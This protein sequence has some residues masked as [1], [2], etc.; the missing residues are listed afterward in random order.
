[1]LQKRLSK[2]KHFN[3]KLSLFMEEIII[4]KKNKAMNIIL[5]FDTA[6]SVDLFT[7]F[8]IYL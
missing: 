5:F 3:N 1:M 8:H 4:K 7:T 2:L 6:E